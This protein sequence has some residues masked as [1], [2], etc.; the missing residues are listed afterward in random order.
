MTELLFREINL[1]ATQLL[2]KRNSPTTDFSERLEITNVR[3][4]QIAKLLVSL[5]IKTI[6][7]LALVPN[8]DL[9]PDIVNK[10]NA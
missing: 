8:F 10:R 2:Q 3:A 4:R 5:I 9:V 6:T 1:L 7:R